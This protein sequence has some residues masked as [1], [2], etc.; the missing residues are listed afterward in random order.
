MNRLEK[1]STRI[2]EQESQDFRMRL[3]EQLGCS[4]KTRRVWVDT[5]NI[6]TNQ[7]RHP[8]TRAEQ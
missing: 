1:I 5:Q 6:F 2:P 4:E 3:Q 8:L 7:T